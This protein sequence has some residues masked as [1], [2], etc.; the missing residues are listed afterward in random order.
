[1][2]KPRRCKNCKAPVR[3]HNGPTGDKCRHP[4]QG[5]PAPV[6]EEDRVPADQPQEDTPGP[7]GEPPAMPD[8]APPPVRQDQ[9]GQPHGAPPPLPDMGGQPVGQEGADAVGGNNGNQHDNIQGNLVGLPADGPVDGGL[10]VVPP[11]PGPVDMDQRPPRGVQVGAD[12]PIGHHPAPPGVNQRNQHVPAQPHGVGQPTDRVPM[13]NAGVAVRRQH[14]DNVQDNVAGPQAIERPPCRCGLLSCAICANRADITWGNARRARANPGCT[15]GYLLCICARGLPTPPPPAYH[16]SGP[17]E[18]ATAP[19][20]NMPPD[21]GVAILDQLRALTQAINASNK[22]DNQ[23]PVNSATWQRVAPTCGLESSQQVFP[24]NLAR[25]VFPPQQASM[26]QP[27]GAAQPQALNMDS[28]TQAMMGLMNN[29]DPAPQI[30][31]DIQAR[32]RAQGIS[33]KTIDSAVLGMYV[34]LSDLLPPIGAS[35]FVNNPELEPCLD[36]DNVVTYRAK[37]HSRKVVNYDTWAQAWT[38]YEKLMVS[39]LGSYVYEF[40]ADYR[41]FIADS[42]KKFTW[43]CV[44]LYDYRHR[45]KLSALPNL[46]SR[47]SFSIP[48]SEFLP[49]ILDATAIRPNAPRCPRC[50]GYDHLLPA[51]PFPE[52]AQKQTASGGQGKGQAGSEICQNFNR[53]RCQLGE[54]CKRIHKC[55]V[56]KG[57]MPFS[58]CAISGPCAGKGTSAT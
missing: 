26:P 23:R 21:M 24:P 1:M 29:N 33:Q 36:N 32:L 12:G 2:G 48:S 13:V 49:V 14:A 19:A 10:P 16:S 40:M 42:N 37:K 43:T 57:A 58:K 53:E 39:V 15:C 4:K 17:E 8:P 41:Q 3:G 47:V 25:G 35:M 5:K 55:R 31:T 34:D 51:C 22:H 50:R 20:N 7:A 56:C 18:G 28:V 30:P 46:M 52:T 6:V 54:K 9:G 44:A 27:R 11:V 45:V 38:V